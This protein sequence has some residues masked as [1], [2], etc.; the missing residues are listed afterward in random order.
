MSGIA[1]AHGWEF[2]ADLVPYLSVTNGSDAMFS[3]VR[4]RTAIGWI[5]EDL[6]VQ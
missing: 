6:G 4:W 1:T 2:I 3:A 5:N